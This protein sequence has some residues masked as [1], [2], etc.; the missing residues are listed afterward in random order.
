[1]GQSVA[2]QF[3][4]PRVDSGRVPST[5]LELTPWGTPVLYLDYAKY[6]NPAEYHLAEQQ[7]TPKPPD[8]G[9]YVPG[10]VFH[11]CSGSYRRRCVI[12]M[13]ANGED[14]GQVEVLG[15]RLMRSLGVSVCMVEYPGYG[16][17][18]RY[19]NCTEEEFLERM[20]LLKR[21]REVLQEDARELG[22]VSSS[23]P[24][25]TSR[26]SRAEQDIKK[27][28]VKGSSQGSPGEHEANASPFERIFD[29]EHYEQALLEE[30]KQHVDLHEGSTMAAQ[31]QAAMKEFFSASSSS[32]SSFTLQ[33]DGTGGSSSSP[34]PSQ[35]RKSI[36]FPDDEIREE[37]IIRPETGPGGWGGV[38]PS[39]AKMVPPA[40]T[41]TRQEQKDD[42]RRR[43]LKE[44]PATA[45]TFSSEHLRQQPRPQPSFRYGVVDDTPTPTPAVRTT[46]TKPPIS[47]FSQAELDLQLRESVNS[48]N[49]FGFFQEVETSSAAGTVTPGGGGGTSSAAASTAGPTPGAAAQGKYPVIYGREIERVRRE[50]MLRQYLMEC[51]AI[52]KSSVEAGQLG[53]SAAAAS[54]DQI[55]FSTTGTSTSASSSSGNR[56]DSLPL[57]HCSCTVVDAVVY[58]AYEYVKR[59][60]QFT[61]NSDVIL[62]GRSIG[63]GPASRLAGLYGSGQ[64]PFHAVI[65]QSPFYSVETAAAGF[66]FGGMISFDDTHWDNAK[67]LQAC[68]DQVPVCILHGDEDDVIDISQNAGRL[69]KE[70]R[71]PV[72]DDAEQ[73]D[74][75]LRSRSKRKS[76]RDAKMTSFKKILGKKH[77][78][79][80]WMVDV[81]PALNK[82]LRRKR[83]HEYQRDKVVRP[84]PSG[85]A[86]A[87]YLNYRL[88]PPSHSRPRKPS[89]IEDEEEVLDDNLDEAHTTSAT[90]RHPR[91]IG[92]LEVVPR[93]GP[94][95]KSQINANASTYQPIRAS[96]PTGF[97]PPGSAATSAAR[98]NR[99]SPPRATAA[100][101]AV[102]GYNASGFTIVTTSQPHDRRSNKPRSGGQTSHLIRDLLPEEQR[103]HEEDAQF[104]RAPSSPTQNQDQ[105]ARLNRVP[106]PELL[107]P[108]LG[109]ESP[110][111]PYNGVSGLGQEELLG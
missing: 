42:E 24:I 109:S 102:S 67:S 10:S 54:G 107:V 23:S 101:D 92:R 95:P 72:D 31:R 26:R 5:G 93:P 39:L 53:Q 104:L 29:N 35:G 88:T 30:N 2:T 63:T 37:D 105:V 81:L 100:S 50:Y 28:R 59:V 73:D 75:W 70:L 19:C 68:R 38:D 20:E 79:V 12:Y 90:D 91:P 110:P 86:P 85:A 64:D 4:F 58:A 103:L 56:A 96:L 62:Y 47:V 98:K 8:S 15:H 106:T 22:L 9:F 61:K 52:S 7:E 49:V 41:R 97:S 83:P 51:G 94:V 3:L 27:L 34:T 60:K 25:S 45:T 16:I 1:M 21:D 17:F 14:L 80:E 40:K 89:Q 32:S 71:P 77:N 87:E 65:L 46:G 99:S 74:R 66:P 11:D 76:E 111:S 57:L 48:N 36:L 69:Y 55:N 6:Y 108:R 82:F 18:K 13:H 33:K 84:S 43:R 78:D 44:E